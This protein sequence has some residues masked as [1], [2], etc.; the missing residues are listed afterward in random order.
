VTSGHI[1]EHTADPCLYLAECLRVLKPGGY[2][3]LEFPTRY[4]H[5][6]LHTQ[7]P[8]AEWLPRPVR[9][10]LLR[11]LVSRVSPISVKAK[12]GY[13]AIVGT[14]LQQISLGLVKRYL[15]RSGHAHS[16]VRV[17]KVAPGVIRAALRKEGASALQPAPEGL[18][19]RVIDRELAIARLAPDALVPSWATGPG[20]VSVTRTPAELSIVCDASLV[21]GDARCERGWATLELEGPF[22]FELTGILSSFITPLATAKIGIFAISTFDTDVVLVKRAALDA[23]LEALQRAGHVRVG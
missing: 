14:N 16:F 12:A 17:Q 9:N 7:L 6:E 5:T 20:F 18:K 19:F 13:T 10:G 8:S 23:A 2:L 21:P 4:H 22:P 15:N 11:L 1:V 3:A